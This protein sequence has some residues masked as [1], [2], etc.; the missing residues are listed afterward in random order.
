MVEDKQSLEKRPEITPG[1][2]IK[3]LIE[4]VEG[5]SIQGPLVNMVGFG[6]ERIT[7]ER[8]EVPKHLKLPERPVYLLDPFT[9][10]LIMISYREPDPRK[11]DYMAGLFAE[12]VELDKNG[13]PRYR[14]STSDVILTGETYQP[15]VVGPNEFGFPPSHIE[16]VEEKEERGGK[17]EFIPWN[18]WLGQLQSWMNEVRIDPDENLGAFVER[19]HELRQRSQSEAVQKIKEVFPESRQGMDGRTLPINVIITDKDTDSWLYQA[20]LNTGIY[21]LLLD[22][23]KMREILEEYYG[24]EPRQHPGFVQRLSSYLPREYGNSNA[25]VI[26]QDE[27]AFYTFM[28]DFPYLHHTF[29]EVCQNDPIF[30]FVNVW[31]PIPYSPEEESEFSKIGIEGIDEPRKIEHG[32]YSAPYDEKMYRELLMKLKADLLLTMFLRGGAPLIK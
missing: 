6:L 31:R 9:R 29:N 2:L 11:K 20:S 14:L 25:A 19:F 28:H 5:R 21:P 7:R 24:I 8:A 3:G 17:E 10:R 32:W 16:V 27:S 15:V 30:A 1:P 4:P 18:V 22:P 23:K 13:E 12:I 26:T